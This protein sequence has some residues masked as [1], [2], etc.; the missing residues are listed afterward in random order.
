MDQKIELIGES[1]GMLLDSV[2]QKPLVEENPRAI[3]LRD[4]ICVLADPAKTGARSPRLIHHWLN[5]DADFALR[6]R[7]LV[8][9][10]LQKRTQFIADDFVIIISPRVARDFAS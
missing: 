2:I 7:R 6:F 3:I 8:S 9:D 4:Q 1:L 10:P 5:I